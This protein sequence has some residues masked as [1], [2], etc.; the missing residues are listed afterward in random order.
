[1]NTPIDLLSVAYAIDVGVH[2]LLLAGAV[3]SVGF[4]QR[5]IWPPP[6]PGSWQIRVTWVSFTLAFGLNAALVLLD[7]NS[8]RLPGGLR[9]TAG[10]PIA[11]VGSLL[12]SWGMATLGTR[13]TSGVAVRFVHGGPYRFTRNPQYLGDIILFLGLS[14]VANSIMLWSTHL[15]L[16]VVFLVAPLAE[17]PWLED[18]F[19]QTYL[20]YKR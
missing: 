20:D 11:I 4:P 13:N 6:G 5:R 8:G 15:L 2:L 1:M 12:T 17:E 14:L 16:V 18:Q 10:V 19:G 9:F 3:W 7:W